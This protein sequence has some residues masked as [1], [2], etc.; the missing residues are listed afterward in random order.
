MANTS[1]A[2]KAVRKIKSRTLRNA[3][4]K[5][6]IKRLTKEIK[7]LADS[8][9]KSEAEELF[10]TVT[11]KIDKAAKVNVFH[12]NTAARYKSRLAKHINKSAGK[13]EKK[14]K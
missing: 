7:E 2:K 11:K 13:K 12:E 5:R 4:I 1:S 10:V 9:K 14:S 6:E 8:G 3:K